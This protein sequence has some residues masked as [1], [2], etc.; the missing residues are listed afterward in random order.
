MNT[1]NTQLSVLDVYVKSADQRAVLRKP[2][3]RGLTGL[4]SDVSL[5]NQIREGLLPP[6]IKLGARAV[7]LMKFEVDA[8]MAARAAGHTDDQIRELVCKLV[9]NRKA[10]ANAYIE[11]VAV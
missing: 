1:E 7:G 9:E 3:I 10:K 6:Y 2:E 11:S 8:V 4:N 5:F